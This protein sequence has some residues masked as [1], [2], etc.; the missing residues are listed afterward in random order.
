MKGKVFAILLFGFILLLAYL[1]GKP[2]LYA[3]NWSNQVYEVVIGG[4]VGDRPFNRS[5]TLFVRSGSSRP[6][7]LNTGNLVDFWL[8]SGKPAGIAGKG[9]IWL[10]TSSIFY[11]G[12]QE[13][14]L[15]GVSTGQRA[16]G[17]DVSR[18]WKRQQERFQQI[19]PARGNRDRNR[20]WPNTP[21]ASTK[22]QHRG[23]SQPD[24]L[25][26]GLSELFGLRSNYQRSIY[27]RTK[28]VIESC[29]P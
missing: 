1:K 13:T 19:G 17:R 12:G 3:N 26:P 18:F 5:G 7:E 15:A 2:V 29:S 21:S 4:A 6:H 22:R 24:W 25:Q 10:A 20:R 14:L 8:V 9:A 27:R 23:H 16:G 11:S 28:L